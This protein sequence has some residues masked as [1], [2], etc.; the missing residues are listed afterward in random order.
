MPLYLV[1]PCCASLP[2]AAQATAHVPC[3]AARARSAAAC[4]AGAGLASERR[5]WPVGASPWRGSKEA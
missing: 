5:V 2:A 1:A 3:G 4:G